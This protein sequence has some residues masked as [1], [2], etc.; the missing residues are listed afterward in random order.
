MTAF[1]LFQ[2]PAGDHALLADG[3]TAALLAPDGNVAWLCW[4][5]VDS[6]PVLLGILDTAR[7]GASSSVPPGRPSWSSAATS[8][9][10]WGCAASGTPP[11]DG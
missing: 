2:H 11:G 4:P 9:P 3:R 10:P 7:G 6:A 8:G 1:P 5:R